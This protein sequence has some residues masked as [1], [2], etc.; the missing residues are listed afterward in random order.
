MR[1]IKFYR[2]LLPYWKKEILILFFSTIGFVL[3]LI[4]PYLTKLIV[5]K[6]YVNKNLKL[7]IFLAMLGGI[8]F[9]IN[10][11]ITTL[12]NYINRFI[13]LQVSFDLNRK[14]FK[15]L[16]G[17]SYRF[18]QDSSTGQNLYKI[19][20]DI[21]R[22][23]QLISDVMPQVLY[24]MPK[25]LFIF[26]IVFYLDRSM[27]FYSLALLPFLYFFLY[28][29]TAKLKKAMKIWIENSQ[30]IFE[31]AQEIL[32][33]IQLIKAFG[34]EI[35]EEKSYIANVINNI[36]LNLANVKLE[37]T[38]SFTIG[39]I[40]RIILGLIVFYGGYQVIKGRMTLGTLSAIA[41]YLN[42]LSSLQ[43]A[44]VYSLQQI[45]LGFVSCERLEIILDAP[46]ELQDK[47]KIKDAA[48]S[49]GAI[50]FRKLTFGY[51]SD[52]LILDNLN[53]C[54]EG[55]SWIGLVGKSGCGKTTLI[56]LLLRLHKPI[57]G[58]ILIDGCN[59]DN[60]KSKSF[61]A[62]IGAVLQ[63]PWLWNDT[64]ENNIR[65]GK[66]EANF[67]E[68]QE[69]ARIA[70]IDDFINNLPDAYQT[71]IGENASKISEGQKQ[72]LAIARAVIKK[73]KILILDEA[74]SSIDGALEA[75]IIDNIR[76]T[77]KD[78]TIIVISHRVSTISNMDLV[79]FLSGSGKIIKGTHEDLLQNNAQYPNY[80][81][82]QLK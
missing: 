26:A 28:F 56:N 82:H 41:L 37:L 42:Q 4:T 51:N 75:A 31:K 19:A 21:E 57:R 77:L 53:F 59:I 44:L 13:K 39:T 76:G 6:A 52:R 30:R 22:V 20:Y 46:A 70:C 16:R 58:E 74:F 48:F 73:P 78:S 33:H 7:F 2:Y 60:V 35:R 38:G 61:Y 71:V 1:Y 3:G 69:V 49:K 23:T 11:I 64:I 80:L 72:R 8:V 54:I 50:E 67:K 40:N 18:F 63:E 66:E 36:R 12:I 55:G 62:Q 9:L 25:A 14:I 47:G 34:K 65:Y 17:F 24:F 45:S 81:A 15:K 43:N 68:V 79:Y 5:D 32:S 27:A 10:G 29:F